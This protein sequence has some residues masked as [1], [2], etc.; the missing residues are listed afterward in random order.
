MEQKQ[1]EQDSDEIDVKQ[2]FRSLGNFFENVGRGILKG[3]INIRRATVSNKKEFIISIIIFIILAVVYKVLFPPIYG[4]S[5]LLRS[6]YI[7]ARYLENEIEKLNALAEDEDLSRLASMLE[8]ETETAEEIIEFELVPYLTEEELIEIK[9]TEQTLQEI[10]DIDD[11]L[12]QRIMGYLEVENR[13]L[14]QIY[15][16]VKDPEAVIKLEQGFIKFIKN[17]DFVK[18]RIEIDKQTLQARKAKLIQESRTLDSLKN[19]LFE[20][21]QSMARQRD[22]GSNN[23][24]LSD[25]YLTNPLEVFERDLALNDQI[26][27][28]EQRLFLEPNFETVDGFT[29]FYEPINW[30]WG[31]TMTMAIF[32]GIGFAYIIIILKAINSYLDKVE[33]EEVA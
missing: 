29:A 20:N 30:G 10:E 11:V 22:Q 2:L 13:R 14:F 5:L 21:F 27:E 1:R 15:V 24:I 19:V 33:R 6:S 9:L 3:I 25:R 28:I 23:V 18:R 17:D 31:K 16:K 7:N 32:A 8:I 12:I 26:L 4:S